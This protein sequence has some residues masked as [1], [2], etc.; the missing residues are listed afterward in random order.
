MIMDWKILAWFIEGDLIA[1]LIPKFHCIMI[2][3]TIFKIEVQF[4]G[5]KKDFFDKARRWAG[6]KLKILVFSSLLLNRH[7]SPKKTRTY[8]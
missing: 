1:N 4:W 7:Q 3:L 5:G 2:T 6:K 8:D